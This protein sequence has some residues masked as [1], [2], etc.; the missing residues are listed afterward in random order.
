MCSNEFPLCMW[1]DWVARHSFSPDQYLILGAEEG[2]YILNLHELH[3]D[4]MEKVQGFFMH[5]FFQEPFGATMMTLLKMSKFSLE[6]CHSGKKLLIFELNSQ[7]NCTP[8]FCALEVTS[9]LALMVNGSVQ[10]SIFVSHYM[11][12]TWFF[13]LT[14]TLNGELEEQFAEFDKK[15]MGLEL[16]TA[17]LSLMWGKRFKTLLCKVHTSSCF[18]AAS[19]LQRKKRIWLHI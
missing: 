8:P 15:C 17:P 11:A 19:C 9:W 4:T 3:E 13:F 18:F 1:C 6:V 10:A 5:A 7:S 14:H 2:I 12:R 16:Q